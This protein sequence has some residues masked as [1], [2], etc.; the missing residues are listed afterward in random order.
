MKRE[1]GIGEK[2]I[3]SEKKKVRK[4]DRKRQMCG[5]WYP[6]QKARRQ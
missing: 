3:V 2:A 6:V 1:V 4:R 5:S